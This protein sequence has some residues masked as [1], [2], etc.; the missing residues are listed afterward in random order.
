M[1]VNIASLPST[2][3]FVTWL[4]RGRGPGAGALCGGRACAFAVAGHSAALQHS[5]S[6]RCKTDFLMKPVSV[7]MLAILPLPQGLPTR[8]FRQGTGI[9]TTFTSLLRQSH[10]R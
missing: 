6:K 4:G 8:F 7:L 10:N 5:T 3:T 2:D 9:L 1:V